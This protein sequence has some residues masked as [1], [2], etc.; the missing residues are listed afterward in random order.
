MKHYDLVCLLC[1][2]TPADLAAE[3]HARVGD[4]PLITL[5]AHLMRD[6]GVS[7][8]ELKANTRADEQTAD[9]RAVYVYWLPSHGT[10]AARPWLRAEETSPIP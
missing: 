5:Q 9:G 1:K 10:Q 6:H 7:I 4:S 3:G 8:E 2:K